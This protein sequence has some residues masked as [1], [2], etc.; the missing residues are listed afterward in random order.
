MRIGVAKV[1]Q[2]GKLAMNFRKYRRHLITQAE[3]QDEIR[4]PAPVVLQIPAKDGLSNVTGGKRADNSSLESGWVIRQKAAY[5]SELPNAAWI[6][7]RRSL[8]EHSVNR[9]GRLDSV[10][11]SI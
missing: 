1:S 5:I 6:G 2:V 4:E 11:A 9:D 8:H 7:K 10:L 3:I